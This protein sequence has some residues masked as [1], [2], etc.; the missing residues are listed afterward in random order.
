[1]AA[2]IYDEEVSLF[3]LED[4]DLNDDEF[5]NEVDLLPFNEFESC[6]IEVPDDLTLEDLNEV[7]FVLEESSIPMITFVDEENI[8]QVNFN[9][10][11]C[12]KCNQNY[13]VKSYFEKHKLIC[14]KF[15]IFT[16]SSI[17][18]FHFIHLFWIFPNANYF[19]NNLSKK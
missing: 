11:V 9:V 14:G 17:H 7:D 15:S 2:C 13:K 16:D 8:Q 10:F 5:I 12:S 3:Q 6:E 4:L 19:S 1:M 18:V